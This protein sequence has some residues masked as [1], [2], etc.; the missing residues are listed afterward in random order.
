MTLY[1]RHA[2]G[3]DDEAD[4][5]DLAERL[6]ERVDFKVYVAANGSQALTVLGDAPVI[7]IALVDHNL[8][9]MNGLELIKIL[10]GL[11]LIKILRSTSLKMTLIMFTVNDEPALIES[12]F[13]AGANMIIVKPY[14]FM[15][16]YRALKDPNSKILECSDCQVIDV[17][18]IRQYR[19][20]EAL[21]H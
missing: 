3:I 11:E 12:A 17:H 4:N 15:E 18:G 13:A 5:R 19:A 6:L 14:G 2:L 8:P 7:S 10:R 21:R 9:D 20:V 16:L 1:G